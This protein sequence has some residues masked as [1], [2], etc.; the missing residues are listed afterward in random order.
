MEMKE[1]GDVAS[2][3]PW[4]FTQYPQNEPLRTRDAEA[5][6]HPLGGTLQL[7]VQPPKESHELQ[8]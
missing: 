8:N 3:D 5:L 6:V 4:R 1:L 2:R 7:M